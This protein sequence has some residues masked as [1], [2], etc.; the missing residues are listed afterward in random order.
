MKAYLKEFADFDNG[1]AFDT[2]LA[3]VS[4]YGF[5]DH[6]WHND[7]MPCILMEHDNGFQLIIWVDFKDPTKA[8]FVEQRQDGTVKQFMFGERDEHGEY[9]EEWQYD[10]VNALIAHVEKVMTA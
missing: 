10:D 8:E 7:A 4:T 1:T 9:T 2:I 5:K 3:A 6:S